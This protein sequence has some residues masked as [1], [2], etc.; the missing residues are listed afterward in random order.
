MP[1]AYPPDFVR[2]VAIVLAYEG[3]YV[4]NPGDPG[5]ETNF[6]ISRRN[7]PGLDIAHLTRGAAIAIYFRDWWTKFDYERLPG[8]I[9]AKLFVL[10]VNMGHPHAVACLQGALRACGQTIVED[11][12]LGQL[13]IDSAHNVEITSAA[14]AEPI[15]AVP[16]MRIKI[17]T[18]GLPSPLVAAI[19]SEAAGYYRRIGDPQFLKGWLNRAYD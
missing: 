16:E 11:G 4:N 18:P 1:S 12:V 13:T 10:A 3:G 15:K 8:A 5:S 9:A 6:G 2:A 14:A 7:Y 17:P 19:R